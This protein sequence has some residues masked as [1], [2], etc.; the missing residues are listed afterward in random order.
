MVS[1][2]H[3]LT[4]TW[5]TDLAGMQK[6]SEYTVRSIFQ[7]DLVARPTDQDPVFIDK[8]LLVA[9]SGAG[10]VTATDPITP[11]RLAELLGADVRLLS[12]EG[13]AAEWACLDAGLS[14]HMP[15]PANCIRLTGP[16]TSKA[17]SRAA[18]IVDEL[19][20]LARPHSRVLLV[21]AVG[22]LISEMRRRGFDVIACDLDGTL[23]GTEV[24]GCLIPRGGADVT[25]GLLPDASA[26]IATGMTIVNGTADRLISRTRALG[27]PLLIYAQSCVSI[28]ARLAVRGIISA[29]VTE[30]WP[31]YFFPGESALQVFRKEPDGRQLNISPI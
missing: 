30:P 2:V 15:P 19:S 14:L 17:H 29:A 13:D 18:L 3:T 27:I 12:G 4:R 6:A 31:N 8:T 24:A 22:S 5:L 26:V 10:Y 20:L 16:P 1:S 7:M 23:Q 9:T 11:T 21:G 25:L 28:A